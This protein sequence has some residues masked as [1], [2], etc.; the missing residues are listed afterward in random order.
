MWADDVLWFPLLL[1]KKKFLGYFKFHGHDVIVEHKLEEV[2]DVWLG[3][4]YHW[5]TTVSVESI[6]LRGF[7]DTLWNHEIWNAVF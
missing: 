3:V 5:W 6:Q 4:E 7:L 2:E 1:Q